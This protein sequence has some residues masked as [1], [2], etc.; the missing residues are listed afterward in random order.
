MYIDHS[1]FVS[2][3]LTT[4]NFSLKMFDYERVKKQFE[5]IPHGT[6]F[7]DKADGT[8]TMIKGK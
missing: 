5:N 8:Q 6:L 7:G 2:Y 4:P 3:T 1:K